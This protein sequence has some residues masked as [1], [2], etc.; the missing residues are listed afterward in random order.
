MAIS[1]IKFRKVISYAAFSGKESL[2]Y[3]V[4]FTQTH[5]SFLATP[6][7]QGEAQ[8]TGQWEGGEVYYT[9]V[10]F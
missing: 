9:L 2:M 8:N 7:H 6:T 1:V 5:A 4:H 3:I 10:H